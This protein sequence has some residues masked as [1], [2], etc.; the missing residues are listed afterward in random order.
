MFG[1]GARGGGWG[2]EQAKI[3]IKS[4]HSVGSTC[5]Y[6]ID[7]VLIVPYYYKI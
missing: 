5:Y 4:K 2:R 3:K 6:P 1:E 7:C